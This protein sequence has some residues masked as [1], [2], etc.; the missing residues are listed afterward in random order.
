MK[1]P[2]LSINMSHVLSTISYA[3]PSGDYLYSAEYVLPEMNSVHASY[4]N[5]QFIGVNAGWKDC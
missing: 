5:G 2:F 3:T 4:I 1:K